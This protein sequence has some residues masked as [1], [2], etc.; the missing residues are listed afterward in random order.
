MISAGFR[1]NGIKP[2]TDYVQMNNFSGIVSN[3]FTNSL[4]SVS[5]YKNYSLN[6]HPDLMDNSTNTGIEI[7]AANKPGKGGESH[8]GHGGWHLVACYEVEKD[9]GNIQFSHIMI[10]ELVSYDVGEIDWHFCKSTNEGG[11]T[12]HIETYYTTSRGTQKL[13]DGTIYL[14]LSLVTNWKRWRT[15]KSPD[16]ISPSYSIFRRLR[17]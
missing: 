14:D 13:R 4:D 12:R 9:S 5:S 3:V 16:Y 6:S 7:K 8:N 1:Q 2:M 15:Y 10:G 11:R 17:S